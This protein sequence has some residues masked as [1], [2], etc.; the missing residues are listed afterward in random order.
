ME[1]Y[2][3][4]DVRLDIF[5]PPFPRP[6]MRTST[7]LAAL[8][9]GLLSVLTF[10]FTRSEATTLQL[11]E[12]NTD[13]FVKKVLEELRA[14]NGNSLPEAVALEAAYKG[15]ELKPAAFVHKDVQAA[16]DKEGIKVKFRANF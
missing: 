12:E 3:K 8:A 2:L 9:L 4:I 14:L 5:S 15:N 1:C 11:P 6:V 7:K 10:L 16:L 13:A